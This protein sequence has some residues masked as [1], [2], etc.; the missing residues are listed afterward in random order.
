M[1]GNAVPFFRRVKIFTGDFLVIDRGPGADGS[2]HISCNTM[3]F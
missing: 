3:M 2:S 1:Q